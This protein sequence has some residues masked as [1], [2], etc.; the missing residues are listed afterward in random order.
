M[1]FECA[2]SRYL[3]DIFYQ[4]TIFYILLL[5]LLCNVSTLH[6]SQEF[7]RTVIL[8]KQKT[9]NNLGPLKMCT[10]MIFFF[11][12]KKKKKHEHVTECACAL[13]ISINLD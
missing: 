10:V 6:C 13:V 4:N 2:L 8:K 7:T 1:P 9:N 11:R 3:T 5:G 12:K